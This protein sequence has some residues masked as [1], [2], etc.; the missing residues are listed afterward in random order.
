RHRGTV[1]ETPHQAFR[2]SRHNLAMLSQEPS[3]RAE[4]QHATVERAAITF[5]DSDNKIDAVVARGL[6]EFFD[7]GA[8]NVHATVPVSAEDGRALIGT[9]THDGAKI[10]ASRV[11]GNKRLREKDESSVFAGG[12]ACKNLNFL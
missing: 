7:C 2:A 3:I 8:G 6:S 9:G 5:D 1:A 12:F 10:E 11:A 4:E